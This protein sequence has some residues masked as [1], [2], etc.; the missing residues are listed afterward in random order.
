MLTLCNPESFCPIDRCEDFVVV[1]QE[2]HNQVL[3]E[4]YVFDYEDLFH[5]FIPGNCG[6]TRRAIGTHVRA[7]LSPDHQYMSNCVT[8]D[9]HH[10]FTAPL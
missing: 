6:I 5:G 2:L 1:L 7:P 3:V 8:V 4:L 9:T 10:F